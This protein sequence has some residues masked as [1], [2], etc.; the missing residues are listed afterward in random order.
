[1]Y[2]PTHFR[3]D[4]P[5]ELHA[6]IDAVPF[7]TLV[8]IAEGRLIASHL[9][10]LLDADRGPNGTLLC[11]VARAN[12]QWRSIAPGDEALAM[13]LGPDA[14]V[15]P[16]WY[17]SKREH[18]RVVPTWNYLAVHAWGPVR[19]FEDPDELRTLVDRLT[20]R[21]E[22]NQPQPWNVAD[23]PESYVRDQL[24]GI[25]G[26]ELES[27]RIEGKWKL[28]QNRPEPDIQGVIDALDASGTSA[29]RA[30]AEAMRRAAPK[31]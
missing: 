22:T 16:N 14:Y 7:A 29:E 18:G 11:H 4:D 19:A 3:Q 2:R 30:T 10:M 28:S 5:A 21:H 27:T 25:I 12:P 17:E 23:A 15:S 31:R 8:T 1:M 6:L 13:F 9:P 24:R 26:L 20:R